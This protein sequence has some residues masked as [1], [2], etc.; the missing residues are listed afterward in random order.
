MF[1]V[2]DRLA[3]PTVYG[4]SVA[5]AVRIGSRVVKLDLIPILGLISVHT[6]HLGL[7]ATY[8]PTYHAPYH[9]ARAFATLDHLSSGR[10]VG[11]SS[12]L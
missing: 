11:I 5:D 9:V 8:S 2:D 3:L 1:F 10:A 7:G 6:S 12:P 4:D